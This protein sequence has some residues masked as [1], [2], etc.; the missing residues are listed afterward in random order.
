MVVLPLA[1]VADRVVSILNGGEDIAGGPPLSPARL[2]L[3]AAV[4]VAASAVVS[5]ASGG[6]V[7]LREPMADR[8]RRSG[9]NSREGRPVGRSRRRA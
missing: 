1:V 8:R 2:S 9:C 5:S 6:F 7:T 3:A 4:C